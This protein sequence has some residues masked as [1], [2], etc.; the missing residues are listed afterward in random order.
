M[1]LAKEIRTRC[2]ALRLVGAAVLLAGLVSGCGQRQIYPVSGQV[3]DAEGNPITQMKGGAV[4]FQAVDARASANS[5]LDEQGRFRLTTEKPGDGAHLGKHRVAIMRPYFGPE[6]PA[7]HVIDP[8]YESF[9]TSGLEVTVE[10]KNNE[11][12]LRVERVKK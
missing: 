10:P 5:S 8:R 11:I 7:P 9:E 3:V 4:E 6:R 2:S 1:G 12:V